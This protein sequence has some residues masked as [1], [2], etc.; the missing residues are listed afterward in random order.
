MDEATIHLRI[1]LLLLHLLLILFLLL[2]L[3]LR[4]HLLLQRRRLGPLCVRFYSLLPL[5]HRLLLLVLPSI[6]EFFSPF[7]ISPISFL[8]L[9][10][11]NGVFR[12]RFFNCSVFVISCQ[13]S[14]SP[15]SLI[16]PSPFHTVE[17]VIRNWSSYPLYL[18]HFKSINQIKLWLHS[19]IHVMMTYI[20]QQF[21]H[22]FFF[23]FWIFAST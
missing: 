18:I 9:T 10:A 4:L 22:S 23:F 5:P 14:V 19:W 15:H 17:H 20:L 16:F 7:A 21:M 6:G 1:R 3:I 8:S 11:L 12:V 13:I 2:K